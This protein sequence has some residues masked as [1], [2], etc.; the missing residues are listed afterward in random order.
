[1][2]ALLP[3]RERFIFVLYRVPPE[4]D[5]FAGQVLLRQ[6]VWTPHGFEGTDRIYV[7]PTLEK[8]RAQIPSNHRWFPRH[9]GD[10]PAIIEQ[11][12][13]DELAAQGGRMG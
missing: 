13:D 12:W 4:N 5:E 11:Y 8:A 6:W 9:E 10:H 3:P 1:M 7:F 2:S